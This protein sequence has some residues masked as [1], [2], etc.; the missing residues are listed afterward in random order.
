MIPVAI[1]AFFLISGIVGPWVA[2]HD[3]KR[4]DLLTRF[5]PPLS[6]SEESLSGKSSFHIL[7]TDTLGRDI[8]SQLLHGTRK[9]VAIAVPAV[10]IALVTVFLLAQLMW[11]LHG[12]RLQIACVVSTV[13]A[14]SSLAFALAYPPF[15]ALMPFVIPVKT[16]AMHVIS[17]AVVCVIIAY[18]V[19]AYA[20]YRSRRFCYR[21]TT[22]KDTVTCSNTPSNLGG[23]LAEVDSLTI[24]AVV[25][26]VVS[27]AIVLTFSRYSLYLYEVPDISITGMLDEAITRVLDRGW[28]YPWTRG[29]LWILITIMASVC[30]ATFVMIFLAIRALVQGSEHAQT[31]RKS[32]ISSASDEDSAP[33]LDHTMQ[34]DNNVSDVV[35]SETQDSGP[36]TAIWQRLMNEPLLSAG[37]GLLVG[38]V[39]LIGVAAT[40]GHT[41]NFY[42]KS[43]VNSAYSSEHLIASR[44]YNLAESSET[45]TVRHCA[46][47][48]AQGDQSRL[49]N[50]LDS[51]LKLALPDQVSVPTADFL[52]NVGLA[53]L[54]GSCVGATFAIIAARLKAIILICVS[55]ALACVYGP[56]FI[57]A[58]TVTVPTHGIRVWFY[59]IGGDPMVSLWT[60]FTETAVS[61]DIQPVM[62]LLAHGIGYFTIL[63]M[64]LVKPRA[65][66]QS[67]TRCLRVSMLNLG[68]LAGRSSY[69][70]SVSA[71][72]Y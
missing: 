39:V 24:L 40:T 68:R 45:T 15:I 9:S 10:T 46:E 13:L 21:E 61:W 57:L 32:D 70:R 52:R 23:R 54:L 26:V 42:G 47:V 69:S 22:A 58:L 37:V 14:I 35:S 30:I 59:S 50:E 27:I 3:P 63:A 66:P 28:E 55:A 43:L 48:H 67:G 11:R 60:R 17:T 1:I 20:Q 7:G 44:V 34:L 16:V 6:W 29:I 53:I 33:T 41:I 2:P 18:G 56:L 5:T 19:L 71:S 64:Q 62:L 4:V 12:F 31:T 72:A 38:Y 25:T 36:L 49:C 65:K 8:F 51:E